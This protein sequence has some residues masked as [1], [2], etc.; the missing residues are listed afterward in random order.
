MRRLGLALGGLAIV[1]AGAASCAY[2][3]TFYL[4]RRYYDRATEGQPYAIDKASVA[5]SPNFT[6]SIDYAKKVIANYPK[7][8][9]VDDAYLLWARGLLG[10]DDP[11]ETVNMLRDFDTKFPNSPLKPDA[12]FYLGVAQRQ[13]RKYREADQSLG[14]FIT[15]APKH[16]LVTYAWLER[17][18]ALVSLER[19]GDAADAS[20][21]LLERDPKS[22]LK[23]RALLSRAEALYAK[24]DF[25]GARNDFHALG[26][27]SDTDEQRLTYLL[28]EVD[29]LEAARSLDEAMSI[30]RSALGHEQE[31]A[32]VVVDSAAL[33]TGTNRGFTVTSSEV[34]PSG[35]GG[36][37]RYGR[38]LMRI[39][40]V[41][42]TAGRLADALGAYA[43][44]QQSYPRTPL[45][46][47]AQFRIAYAYETAAD[48]FDRARLEYARVK[49]QFAASPFNG[50]ALQRLANLDRVAQFRQAGRDSSDKRAEAGFL[51]AELYLFQNDKPERALEE[52][53]RVAR[54]FAG[55]PWE[56]KALNAQAWV[57]SRKLDRK[58]EA[59][60]LFWRVVRRHPKTEAQLAARD[61][62]EAEGQVVPAEWIQLPD[63]PIVP[64]DTTRL[65]R[66]P[67]TT[68]TIGPPPG[69]LLAPADSMLFRRPG[70]AD[71][72]AIPPRLVTPPPRR[73][74]SR[75]EK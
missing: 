50:Q 65:S 71:S 10:K 30:L 21:R 38:I 59:D 73:D 7:S 61:Y 70:V 60:T 72:V 19:W 51:L 4:A 47:E 54:E 63:R 12:R 36:S 49:D 74:T 18:R 13:A 33:T 64:V 22:K 34:L 9:W 16:D 25:A 17:A 14:E 45:A 62:L 6:K 46:A 23:P 20:T 35:V 56:A 66:P 58:A 39:G 69:V 5:T 8:K 68:P 24:G 28:R 53:Q 26:L 31:P 40:T 57:L 75:V 67:V 32:I 41:H 43:R 15:M 44:I 29:C 55:T 2:Y 11:L 3:N 48:N 27:M 42:M 52:Y 37:D 1:A